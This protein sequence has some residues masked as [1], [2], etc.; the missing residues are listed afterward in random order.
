[1]PTAAQ[2][3]TASECVMPVTGMT[4]RQAR[5]TRIRRSLRPDGGRPQDRPAG[6]D[7]V[8]M[9]LGKAARPPR[10]GEAG[11]PECSVTMGVMPAS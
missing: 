7:R 1:M 10:T 5:M 4:S 11:L 8:L 2:E 9:A 3:T 6:S